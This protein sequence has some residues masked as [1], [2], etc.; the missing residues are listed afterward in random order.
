[1][2]FLFLCLT[3]FTHSYLDFEMQCVFYMYK[4]L[5]SDQ[6]HFKW[7]LAPKVNSTD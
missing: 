3:Y 1:M 4:H 6:A 5:H 2:I 7:L